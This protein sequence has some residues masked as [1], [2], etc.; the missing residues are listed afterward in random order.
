MNVLSQK[1]R[2]SN[3]FYDQIYFYVK[4]NILFKAERYLHNTYTLTRIN[5]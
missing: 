3:A 4:Q 2:F 5:N 1:N